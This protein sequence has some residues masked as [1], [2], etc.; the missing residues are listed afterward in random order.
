MAFPWVGVPAWNPSEVSGKK[1]LDSQWYRMYPPEDYAGLT[2]AQ[3]FR[4]E[5]L[6]T[7]PPVPVIPLI[8][9]SFVDPFVFRRSNVPGGRDAPIVNANDP[10]TETFKLVKRSAE[11]WISTE[12]QV[13]PFP[14]YQFDTL[15]THAVEA[16]VM[17]IHGID[18]D[19][20]KVAVP[21]YF[22][23]EAYPQWI[24]YTHP[25]LGSE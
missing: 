9:P 1:I 13:Y 3:R 21:I 22:G 20:R 7:R 14:M 8:D 2:F 18:V 23:D 10:L 15:N 12:N 4:G 24:G 5:T 6:R 11:L 25:R 17:Q 16:D 19:F